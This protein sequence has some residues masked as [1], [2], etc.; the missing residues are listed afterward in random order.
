MPL[1]ILYA[2][3]YK[4]VADAVKETL[5]EEGF[6]V[7]L[8]S[9]GAVALRRISGNA[10]YDLFIVDNH[11][12]NV[13]G[14]ELI[15]HTRQLSHRLSIPIIMLSATDAHREA[16]QAGVN[17]FLKKPEGVKKL[18]ETVNNLIK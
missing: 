15:R 12:P 6:R 1:T 18:V 13:N 3:D 4:V 7:V 5:E 2:E 16:Y 11:L 17:V 10:R 9:D 8:C 14:I